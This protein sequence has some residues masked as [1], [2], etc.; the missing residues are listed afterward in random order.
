MWHWFSQIFAKCPI[1][2]TNSRERYFQ[3]CPKLAIIEGMNVLNVE[4]ENA[5]E[6]FIESRNPNEEKHKI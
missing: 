4:K 1:G 6:N 2:K 3:D 5:I